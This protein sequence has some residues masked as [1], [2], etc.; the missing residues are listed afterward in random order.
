MPTSHGD[1]VTGAEFARWMEEES[2]FRGRIERRMA[3]GFGEI[4]SSVGRIE[5]LQ[6]EANGRVSK[7]EQSIAVMQ[8]EVEAIKSEDGEI[9]RT[10]KSILE[11]GCH[12]YVAHRTV[13][14][15]LDGA[16]SVTDGAGDVRP[17]FRLPS[18]SR[19]QKAIA[20]VGVSALLIP[21]IAELFKFATEF[22]HFLQTHP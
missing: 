6:R 21:A 3:D 7:A 13:L 16:E 17:T 18:L 8:R 22:L 20:G 2:A 11:H 5:L 9:E 4:K 14:G 12:Q 15:V 19:R 1:Y 10:V